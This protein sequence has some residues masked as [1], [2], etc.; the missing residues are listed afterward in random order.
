MMAC[1]PA[2]DL[3]QAL[4][5]L[6][7]RGVT[8]IACM[9]TD[10]DMQELGVTA[11]PDLCAAADISFLP[12]PIDDFGLPQMAPFTAL[13]DRLAGLIAQGRHVCVHC[14]AGIGRSGMVA[15]GLLIRQGHSAADALAMVSAARGVSVPDTVEQAEFVTFLARR[16]ECDSG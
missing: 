9:L 4:A 15:A 10:A 11:E 14:R 6:A 1:P 7:T 5:E 8:D 16:M 2:R 12:Y 3:R 13:I